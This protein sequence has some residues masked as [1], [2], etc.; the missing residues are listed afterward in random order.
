M[1]TWARSAVKEG[2]RLSL[3]E[4]TGKE[5]EGKRERRLLTPRLQLWVQGTPRK[6]L[7]QNYL[8]RRRA[9]RRYGWRVEGDR[10]PR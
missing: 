5:P 8:M 6:K 1:A 3:E 4:I 2:K 9:A 10:R 7:P